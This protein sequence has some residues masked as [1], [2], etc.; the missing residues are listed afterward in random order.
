M[1]LFQSI[2]QESIDFQSPAFFKELTIAFTELKAAKKGAAESE[3][4]PR[5]SAVVKHHTGLNIAFNIGNIDP[6]VDIPQVDKNHPLVNSLIRNYVS[7]SDG[8]T[9]IHN[10]GGQVRGSVNLTTGKVTGI[11]TEVKSTINL[12]LKMFSGDKYSAE[13][14]AAVTLHEVGHLVTYYEYITRT[15]TTNQVLAGVSKALD[16]SGNI[17]QREAVLL[18]AKQALK[19]KDF[20]EKELAKSTNT[21]VVEV[22]LVSQIVKQTESE[23]G[24][25][26]YDF[27]SWEMLADQYVARYGAHR[28]L[29]T[30]LEKIY[31]SMWNISFRS[32]PS[33]L[34]MEALKLVMLFL[35]PGIAVFFIVMDG[36][37]DGT[38]DRPGVRMKRVRNQI[39]ENM[40]DKELSKDDHARLAAD[41][42]V[43]DDVIKRIED[44]RQFLEVVWNTISPS[45]R[46][47]YKQELLQRDL[48]AIAANDLF[49]KASEL[50]Q[51]Q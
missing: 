25:N 37:G 3:V 32:L 13:E 4:V 14:I 46:K 17:E 6:C 10:A 7:S 43:I 16:G 33:Y 18:S 22:V 12:P 50:R 5:L 39:V 9:M 21:K 20:D 41:L 24:S 48:E 19:L 30:A 34:A 36:S 40:K 51:L 27:S 49:V 11:F 2:S 8:L 38:Y 47:A 23:L 31:G 28:H 26:V 15:V 35:A 44:R 45:S 42:V 29:V 1:R